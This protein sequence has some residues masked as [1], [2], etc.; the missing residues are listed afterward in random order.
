MDK[1]IVVHECR[2]CPYQSDDCTECTKMGVVFSLPLLGHLRDGT[3][4]FP[5]WCPL[6]GVQSF[7]GGWV[8][9]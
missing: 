3:V 4:T 9:A 6:Q 5:A 1:V 7:K 2:A 8:F